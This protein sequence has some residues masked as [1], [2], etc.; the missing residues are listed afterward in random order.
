MQ[1]LVQHFINRPKFTIFVIL[2]NCLALTMWRASIAKR[3]KKDPKPTTFYSLF[4]CM[5]QYR[6]LATLNKQTN[7]ELKNLYDP[8]WGNNTLVESESPRRQSLNVGCIYKEC[9]YSQ[10]I[11]DKTSICSK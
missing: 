10:N 6:T 11:P 8:A 3:K 4:N 7:N 1:I 5:V 2:S 9:T